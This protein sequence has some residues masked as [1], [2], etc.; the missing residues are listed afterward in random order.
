MKVYLNDQ[1]AKISLTIEE[2]QNL[3]KGEPVI[4]TPCTKI[5]SPFGERVLVVEREYI[6]VKKADKKAK[7]PLGTQAVVEG[8]RHF[9]G[10]AGKEIKV[11]HSEASI[12]EDSRR[13]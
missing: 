5:L 4:G 1:S 8:V 3:V 10:K 9:Y 7:H 12:P 2:V 13:V 6:D 11:G